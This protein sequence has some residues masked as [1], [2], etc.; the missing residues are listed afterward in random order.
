MMVGDLF[1]ALRTAHSG[2]LAQQQALDTAAQNIANVNTPGYARRLVSFE[3]NVIAGEG[4]G[5]RLSSLQRSVDAGLMRSFRLELSTMQSAYVHL[6]YDSR[7]Q[8]QFGGIDANAAL[9]H[10]VAELEAAFQSLATSPESS[11]DQRE[12]ISQAESTVAQLRQTSATIQDL[13][14]EADREMAANVEEVSTLLRRIA[15]F[16]DKIVHANE[17]NQS[18]ADAEDARDQ[19]LDRL[20]ELMDVKIYPRPRGDV[21]VFTGSGRTLVD[22]QAAT[23]SHR[24]ASTVTAGISYDS[25]GFDG[26]TLTIAGKSVDITSEIRGGAIAGLLDLRDHRLVDLQ[27]SVD[28]LAAGLRDQ[29]NAAH[30]QGTAWPGATLLEGSRPVVNP[31]A[32][33]LTWAGD[34]DTA[35]ILFDTD[36]NEVRRTTVRTLLGGA[37]GGTLEDI[38]QAMDA[39]L[40]PDGSAS[41][42]AGGRLS[43]TVATAGL[44]IGILDVASSAD[45]APAQPATLTHAVDTGDGSGLPR[46]AGETVGFSAFF[47]LN[48]VFVGGNAPIAYS[49]QLFVNGFTASAPASLKLVDA[50][51]VMV[52]AGGLP[53]DI[54]VP[55]GA[56]LDDIAALLSAVPGMQASVVSEGGGQRLVVTSED[57]RV[58]S[59]VD[60][61]TAGDHLLADLGFGLSTAG[62][63]EHIAV[64]ED[65]VRAPSLL[66]TGQPAWQPDEAFGG[67]YAVSAGDGSMARAIAEALSSPSGQPA[68]GRI[69]AIIVSLADYASAIVSGH[70]ADAARK[71]DEAQF[72][73]SLVDSL[74]AQSQSF[75]GVNLDEEMANLIV[76]EEAY[77]AAARVITA[78]QD[79]FDALEAAVA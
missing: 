8:D 19:A 44:G 67:R 33:S 28:T 50:S 57:G 52:G 31:A 54:A 41:F 72:E 6:R 25:G 38:Q 5:V 24:P 64:R 49:S 63:A 48:D 62:S 56:S 11:L 65:L 35:L 43:V 74:S 32:E 14:G 77:S 46:S 70:S 40:Q 59:V 3:N 58:F 47:G 1:T 76:Y 4:R 30:N 61:S 7:I 22:D 21:V 68:S 29:V 16:N 66:A 27:A 20:S 10:A 39:W 79:M 42:D 23:L 69:S 36:G 53:A 37:A 71:S 13:R 18:A 55:A 75:S 60:D 34:A 9:P 51:G 73:I 78:I 26:I 15:D 2:L 45:G 17:M 12:V